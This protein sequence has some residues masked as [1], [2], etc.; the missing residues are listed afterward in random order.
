MKRG[1]VFLGIFLW[2]PLFAEVTLVSD[3]LSGH[4]TGIQDG[5]GEFLPGG[6]WRSTGGKILY[7]LGYPV[8]NGVFEIHLSGWTAPAQ[9]AEKSHPLSGWEHANAFTHWDQAGSFW[10]WRIGTG[11]HPFKVLAR[12]DT[13]SPREEARVGDNDRVNDGFPHRY[14]VDWNSGTVSFY[15]DD[16]LLQRWTFD[17]F[18][19]RYFT[20]GRDDWYFA[21]PAPPPVFSFLRIMDRDSTVA[22]P[23][24]TQ[25]PPDTAVVPP[26]TSGSAPDTTTSAGP[27]SGLRD[28]GVFRLAV[29]PNPGN[30][31]FRIQ[32]EHGL[33]PAPDLSLVDMTGRIVRHRM[34]PEFS[35][36]DHTRW[37]WD[38]RDEGGNPAASGVY[39]V[40]VSAPGYRISRRLVLLR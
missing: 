15:F 14:R 24:S 16:T 17:R 37:I 12:P 27:F 21:I 10:N 9:G 25:S 18:A 34:V 40:V 31:Y 19:L 36:P 23:D 26:D 38:G 29:H 33:R 20:L 28:P 32:A 1:F 7:D 2:L 8:I 22:V 30:A 5:T 6:G 3:T 39:L 11:Y 13:L 35:A 4:T